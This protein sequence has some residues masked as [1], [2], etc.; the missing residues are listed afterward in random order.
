MCMT[1]KSREPLTPTFLTDLYKKAEISKIIKNL[2]TEKY[3]MTS[4]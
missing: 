3:Y 2:L 4:R 1:P